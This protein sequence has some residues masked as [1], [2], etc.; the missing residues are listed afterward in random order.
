[1]LFA[2]ARPIF[3]AVGEFFFVNTEL[4]LPL[5]VAVLGG[6]IAFILSLHRRRALCLIGAALAITAVSYLAW[7]PTAVFAEGRYSTRRIDRHELHA[8]IACGPALLVGL[9]PFRLRGWRLARD[10]RE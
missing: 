2:A 5:G 3:E 4:F 10:C 1:M 6:L 8:P 9:T 7:E